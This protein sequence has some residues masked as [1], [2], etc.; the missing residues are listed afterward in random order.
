MN[1][2]RGAVAGGLAALLALGAVACEVENGD[3]IDDPLGD[4]TLDDGGLDDG[5]DQ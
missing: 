1:I 3:P 2:R 4:D 5:V